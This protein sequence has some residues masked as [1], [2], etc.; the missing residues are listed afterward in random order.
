MASTVNHRDVRELKLPLEGRVSVGC[1]QYAD[2][3]TVHTLWDDYRF[4]L[5]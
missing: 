1:S 2:I 5:P 4:L 3:A